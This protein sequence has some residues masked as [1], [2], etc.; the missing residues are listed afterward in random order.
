MNIPKSFQKEVL[1]ILEDGYANQVNRL[2]KYAENLERDL[3]KAEASNAKKN[4]K[5]RRLEKQLEELTQ[6]LEKLK[7]SSGRRP[8]ISK[9]IEFK[10]IELRKLG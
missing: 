3:T 4:I 5:I 1:S 8:K 9:D 6:E 2:N 10:I 7:A